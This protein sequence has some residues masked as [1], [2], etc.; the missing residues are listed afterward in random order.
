MNHTKS[1][2]NKVYA[3]RMGVAQVAKLEL[4]SYTLRG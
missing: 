2:I 1:K 4:P 3:V